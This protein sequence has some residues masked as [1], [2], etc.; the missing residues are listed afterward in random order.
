MKDL[1]G[2]YD[3]SEIQ[4]QEKADRRQE[5]HTDEKTGDVE[6]SLLKSR[7]QS[8]DRGTYDSSEIHEPEKP[9]AHYHDSGDQEETLKLRQGEQKDRGVYDG[10]EI[11]EPEKPARKTLESEEENN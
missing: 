10:S 11:H 9:G 5:K 4:E 7:D 6:E 2:I 8:K 3:S 1:K